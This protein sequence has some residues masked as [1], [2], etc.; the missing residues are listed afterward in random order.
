MGPAAQ[1]TRPYWASQKT[2][3]LVWKLG[4]TFRT[5]FEVNTVQRRWTMNITRD[6]PCGKECCKSCDFW[7]NED[8]F[9]EIVKDRWQIV[10]CKFCNLVI[11]S[12]SLV[13]KLHFSKEHFLSH[14]VVRQ[15]TGCCIVTGSYRPF[16]RSAKWLYNFG[17]GREFSLLLYFNCLHHFCVTVYVMFLTCVHNVCLMSTYCHLSVS[18]CSL[19]SCFVV[20]LIS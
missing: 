15:C 5:C 6:C 17:V 7:T 14:P 8:I 18:H 4:W 16:Q 12:P 3:E 10:P 11:R 19:L 1:S 9:G 20:C 13:E 2:Y